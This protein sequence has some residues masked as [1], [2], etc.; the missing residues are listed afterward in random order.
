MYNS[1][2]IRH[3]DEDIK[4]L[5]KNNDKQIKLQIIYYYINIYDCHRAS[6]KIKRCMNVIITNKLLVNKVLFIKIQIFPSF[7]S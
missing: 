1:V 4:M 2:L 3:S 5:N 6:V 7:F